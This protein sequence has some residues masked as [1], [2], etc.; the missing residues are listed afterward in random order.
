M[1]TEGCRPFKH[2]Y[3]KYTEQVDLFMVAYNL[4]Q[5]EFHA[6]W[7]DLRLIIQILYEFLGLFN[8]KHRHRVIHTGFQM[9][10]MG[11]IQSLP[12]F[13]ASYTFWV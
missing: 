8:L 6:I 9:M 7:A 10:I 1:R 4:P 5:D 11:A 13:H 2:L 12:G 3:P